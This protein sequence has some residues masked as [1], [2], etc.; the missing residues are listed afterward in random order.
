M[1]N[2]FILEDGEQ[3][4]PFTFDE[5]MDMGLDIHTRV[6]TSSADGWQDACDMPEFFEYFEAQGIYF[7]TLDN[8]ASFWWRLLAFLIDYVILSFILQLI[9]FIL[10]SNGITFNLKSLDDLL[11]LSVSKLLILQL[12]SSGTLI[13]YNA[14]G[15][16]SAM[17]GSLGKRVCRMVVVDADGVGLTF[18]N[19][20]AR[21]FGKVLSLIFW[22]LGFLSIFFTEHRQALHDILA[23]TYVVKL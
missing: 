16:A 17:K 6:L 4:G 12:I 22:G 18:L 1:T 13:I 11:K 20:L 10:A 14:A 19:A 3:T 2:Y 9:F 8:L 15:E 7:P 5:L 23:K 21:S